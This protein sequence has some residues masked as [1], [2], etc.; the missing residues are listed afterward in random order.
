MIK[1]MH[2]RQKHTRTY[3]RREAVELQVVP[4]RG[5]GGGGCAH[6]HHGVVCLRLGRLLP[7][8]RDD[9]LH[10][11]CCSPG[12]VGVID[13]GGDGWVGQVI[14]IWGRGTDRGGT[15]RLGSTTQTTSTP[16]RAY[17]YANQTQ[18]AHLLVV[19]HPGA[20]HLGHGVRPSPLC[21]PLPAAGQRLNV[22][23]C[24]LSWLSDWGVGPW[25]DGEREEKGEAR[26]RA[27]DGCSEHTHLNF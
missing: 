9:E 12:G 11:L 22:A 7:L 6:P 10:L 18:S 20:P 23:L 4:R 1:R 27:D 26:R 19:E 21:L 25:M 3:R 14:H 17:I 2:T 5:R 8:A 15:K 24:L 13:V 16:P